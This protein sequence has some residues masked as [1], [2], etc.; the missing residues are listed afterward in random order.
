MTTE[1]L[2]CTLRDGAYINGAKFGQ[3]ALKGIIKHLQDASVEIIECGW[4]KNSPH[5]S[6]SSYFHTPEDLKPYIIEK[7]PSVV[8]VAMIDFDRY[9]T[10]A[11]PYC[12]GKTIDA[13]RV[14]FPKGKH[15]EGF[16][17]AEKIRQK[18]Y[19]IFIQAANTL[20]YSD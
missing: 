5:E 17:V 11:L 12:D 19:K 9:D 13:V 1:L 18:G 8:Y 6:G 10:S 16:A 20:A 2:D 7:K 14:V 4:L 15:T 3:A